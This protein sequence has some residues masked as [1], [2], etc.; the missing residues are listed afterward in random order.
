MFRMAFFWLCLLALLVGL[1]FSKRADAQASAAVEAI[2]RED[3]GALGDALNRGMEQ[4][5]AAAYKLAGAV[6][7]SSGCVTNDMARAIAFYRKAVD[8]GDRGAAK[9]LGLI[10]AT[11]TGVKQDY[12]IS[13]EWYSRSC[14][15]RS[16]RGPQIPES[17]CEKSASEDRKI[18]QMEAYAQALS[19]LIALEAYEY[20]SAA[21]REN[22]FG[23]IALR[24][25]MRDGSTAVR[26]IKVN[27]MPHT[28]VAHLERVVSKARRRL[29]TPE[30]V[31]T[32]GYGFIEL[33]F[34][35]KLSD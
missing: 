13:A 26:A 10:Y 35:Y 28:L 14:G 9:R 32:P 21:L 12:L 23:S 33:E 8:L 1:A 22:V 7:E 2:S 3:C 25:S 11:G 17:P 6:Y 30:V 27:R 15:L 34:K 5:E 31:E 4:N 16:D 18:R 24:I 29:P 19:D 20:P